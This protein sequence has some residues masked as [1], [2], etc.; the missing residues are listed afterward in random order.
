MDNDKILVVNLAKGR[1][2]EDVAALFGALLISSIRL[3]ALGR[4]NQPET[5]R[6]PFYLY[7][8][9]FQTFTTQSLANMLSE[10]RK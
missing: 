8:D 10:L 1:I 6:R 4:A 2:G 7:L 3:A 5:V 9:G